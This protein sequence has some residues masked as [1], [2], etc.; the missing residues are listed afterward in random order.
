MQRTDFTICTCDQRFCPLLLR[1]SGHAAD[2]VAL[3]QEVMEVPGAS[4]T[5][6]LPFT[7][8]PQDQ[9]LL[10]HE[11]PIE[12]A[13]LLQVDMLPKA[14]V[15]SSAIGLICVERK[16]QRFDFFCFHIIHACTM[17]LVPAVTLS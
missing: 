6:S 17:Q 16:L 9:A 1:V 4:A 11:Q 13:P 12:D 10:L 2:M 15:C 3:P 7:T 14:Q 8:T 5:D